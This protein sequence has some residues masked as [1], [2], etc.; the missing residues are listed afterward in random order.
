MPSESFPRVLMLTSTLPRWPG[1]AEPAFILDLARVMQA[2]AVVELIAPH[3]PGAARREVLQG[4]P[5]TR[6]RYWWPRWQA[7]AYQGGITWR[8]QENPW[9]LLQLPGLFAALIWTIARRLRQAPA[10]DLIHAHWL[11]PQGLAALLARRLAN[12]AVPIL[13]TSHGGDL[14]GL[15]GV[16][17]AVLKR[18]V[19]RGCE[20][21][22]VVSRAMA[23]EATRLAP[24]IAPAVI[25]M[26]TDLHTRFVPGP[27]ALAERKR[28][29]IFVGRL[30]PKKGL[31]HLLDALH[32]LHRDGLDLRLTV[33]GHGPLQPTLRAQCTTLGLD[34][35]VQ[36]AG[37]IPHERLAAQYQSAMLA[38]FP[39][40]EAADGDQEGFGLVM[41]EAMGCGCTVV[42]SALPAVRDVI[43]DGETGLLVAPGSAPALAAAIARVIR[44]PALAERIAAQGRQQALSRFDWTVT[45]H[46]FEQQYRALLQRAASGPA[47]P[48]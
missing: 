30:V 40:V 3:A 1:D 34:G 46:A 21:I 19:L 22:S 6:F 17:F 10:I 36:F 16:M 38:V 39:F 9:R 24:G 25:P 47:E 27:M 29:L 48:R 8:L 35:R 32:L 14:F 5:V 43:Q 45:G 42:A 41:V 18:W 44:D 4:V 12:R 26:G 37:P 23:A 11:L 28:Q 31:A 7:V 20:G 15:R 13:C 33:V 2:R